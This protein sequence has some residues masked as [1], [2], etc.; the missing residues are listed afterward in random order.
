[1]NQ[2]LS[3]KEILAIGLMTFSLFLGAGNIIFPPTLGHDAGTDIWPAIGG[4]LVTGVGLPLLGVAAVARA[5]GGIQEIGNRV[6]P[7]FSIVISI[8]TYLSIG[9]LLAIPR[10]GAVAYEIGVAP[11]LSETARTS[12]LSLF[13]YTI[14]FFGVTYWLCLNP[15]KLVDRFGKVIT[16]FM[17]ALLAILLIRGAMSPLGEA[18]APVL[19][20]PFSKGFLEGY[21]TMDALASLVFGGVVAAAVQDRGVT[22]RSKQAKLIIQAGFIAAIGLGLL[23]VG[24]GYMGSTSGS[25]VGKYANGGELITLLS[26]HLLGSTGLILLSLAITFAC[27]TTAVGLVTSCASFFSRLTGEKV[28][29]RIMLNLFT[30]ASLVIA[31]FGLSTILKISVP[32]LVTLY[33]IAIVLILLTLSDSLFRGRRGVYVGATI[34]AAL[35]SILDGFGAAGVNVAPI[36]DSL[37]QLP[38]LGSFMALGL[39]WMI[40][41]IIGAIIG[42]FFSRVSPAYTEAHDVA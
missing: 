14:V 28:S 11:F 29:Y 20:N 34:G 17:I 8:L 41:A 1:M 35:L 33:P 30:L 6:H 22:N 25:A 7:A 21:N 39:G 2:S 16:P 13:I 38:V 36:T 37:S 31:N 24:L 10:T 9:P 5:G 15:G 26:Q 12:S 4:F 18:Q 23:Y 3:F 19:P 42:G 27:L 40:P 32:I